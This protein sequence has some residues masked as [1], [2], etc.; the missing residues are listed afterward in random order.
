MRSQHLLS[1]LISA[2]S[3]NKNKAWSGRNTP[4]LEKKPLIV[5]YK[6]RVNKAEIRSVSPENVKECSED[7]GLDFSKYNKFNV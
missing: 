6:K 3:A 7:M 1:K 4:I 2:M 5:Q